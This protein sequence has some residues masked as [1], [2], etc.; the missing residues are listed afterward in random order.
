MLFLNGRLEESLAENR[1]ALELN[2]NS[3]PNV[4]ID[5]ARILIMLERYDEALKI[6]ASLPEGKDRDYVVALLYRAPGRKSEADA[7]LAQLAAG[8]LDVED[9]VRLAEIYSFRGMNEK[10]LTR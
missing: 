6:L 7:A 5:I 10:A 9:H 2:P 3:G 4:E 8:P 1:R